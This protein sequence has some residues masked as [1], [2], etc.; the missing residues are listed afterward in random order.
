MSLV[1][2]ARVSM[3][4]IS[5]PVTK[6]KSATFTETGPPQ[7]EAAFRRLFETDDQAACDAGGNA[8]A[9]PDAVRR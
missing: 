7:A 1:G 9:S 3:G 4:L 5:D 8:A 2:Y 6:A